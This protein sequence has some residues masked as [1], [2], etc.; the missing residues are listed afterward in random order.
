MQN[1]VG[2]NYRKGWELKVRLQN[3]IP[4]DQTQEISPSEDKDENEEINSQ[5][6]SKGPR[7]I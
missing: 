6:K 1:E 7:V 5:D 3:S 4:G 2:C